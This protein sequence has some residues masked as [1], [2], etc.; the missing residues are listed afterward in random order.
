MSFL[1][2]AE[3]IR[4][5]SFSTCKKYS[6]KLPHDAGHMYARQRVRKVSFSENFAYVLNKWSLTANSF[7]DKVNF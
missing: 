1:I 6:E 3:I 4:N 7:I 5:N 2:F